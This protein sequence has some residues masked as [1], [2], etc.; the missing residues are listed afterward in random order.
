MLNYIIKEIKRTMTNKK[1][2]LS[3]DEDI[4]K[5]FQKFC[6]ENDVMLSKRIERLMKEHISKIKGGKK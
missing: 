2:T 3:I 5:H 1:V 6:E 4:Y